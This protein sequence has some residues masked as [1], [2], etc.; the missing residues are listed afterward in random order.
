MEISR[1]ISIL[2]NALIVLTMLILVP[3]LSVKHGWKPYRYFTFLSNIFCA[4]ASALV[5][6]FPTQYWAFII[7]FVATVEVTLTFLTVMLLLGPKLGYKRVLT[8]HD[9]WMHIT[10]PV[11]AIVS[12][13][14]F[15]RRLISA[16]LAL[17][18]L[19]PLIPYGIMYAYNVLLAPT[20]KRWDDFYGFAKGGK[21][22]LYLI[23]MLLATTAICMGLMG[24]MYL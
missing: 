17:L 24:I 20:E 9:F 13:C 19:V 7:K 12:L 11:F 3:L 2:L 15:E 16:W 22:W 8:G 6:I 14:F 4:I 23:I 5:I 18:G 21:W 10:N 1:L